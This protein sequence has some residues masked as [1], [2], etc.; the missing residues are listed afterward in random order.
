MAVPAGEPRPGPTTSSGEVMTA[1]EAPPAGV[2]DATVNGT[3]ITRLSY[4]WYDRSSGAYSTTRPTIAP[5]DVVAVEVDGAVKITVNS[6]VVPAQFLVR[7]FTAFDAQGIP[8]SERPTVECAVETGACSLT[9][10]TESVTAAVKLDSATVFVTVEVYYHID[11]IGLSQP[12]DI[13]TYGFRV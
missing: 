9:T 12:F 11:S 3:A 8:S 6:P 7:E 4:L 1:V 5:N 13:V 10:D 2:P